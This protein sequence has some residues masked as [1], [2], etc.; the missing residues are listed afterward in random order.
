ML[1]DQMLVLGT[2]TLKDLAKL[3]GAG[4]MPSFPPVA[5]LVDGS[6]SSAFRPASL[7]LGRAFGVPLSLFLI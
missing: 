2:S 6:A 7:C 3:D 1:D 5:I 4:L